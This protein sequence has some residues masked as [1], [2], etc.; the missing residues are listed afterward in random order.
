MGWTV[1]ISVSCLVHRR[2][3]TWCDWRYLLPWWDVLEL[4]THTFSRP[5]WQLCNGFVSDFSE[6]W[7]SVLNW[8][9]EFVWNF[10]FPLSLIKMFDPICVCLLFPSILLS[11]LAKLTL[12]YFDP[13]PCSTCCAPYVKVVPSLEPFLVSKCYRGARIIIS[14]GLALYVR[15][16]LCTKLVQITAF[17]VVQIAKLAGFIE[18]CWDHLQ[19][20]QENWMEIQ[21]YEHLFMKYMVPFRPFLWK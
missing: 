14:E 9:L 19:T 8:S 4:Y 1:R 11:A 12:F 18:G 21:I 15:E 5:F 16:M 7:S 2:P 3:D 10:C 17:F 20:Q 13:L 6:I